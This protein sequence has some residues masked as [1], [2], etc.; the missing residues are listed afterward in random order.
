MP[1]IRELINRISFKVNPGD[2]AKADAAMEGMEAK[3]AGTIAFFKSL[4]GAINKTLKAIGLLT[5]AGAK[6]FTEYE[7]NQA[8]SRFFS[9]TQEEAKQL[10]D[11]LDKLSGSEIISKR[12]REQAEAALSK[13]TVP[14]DQIAR[15]LPILED[16]T[17]ARPDLDFEQVVGLTT[18]FVKT[19]D[20]DALENLGAV[21]KDTAEAFRLSQ[22]N[23]STAI[24][25]QRNLFQFLAENLDRNKEKIK[26]NADLVRDDL[27]F[28]FKSLAKEASDF[29]LNFGKE[30]APV[31]KEI[32]IIIRDLIKEL[33]ESDEFWV[34]VKTGAESTL[35]VIKEAIA[36]AKI[37]AG[38][39]EVA[40]I[41]AIDD[42]GSLKT[43]AKNIRNVFD[44]GY[45]EASRIALENREKFAE[46][47]IEKRGGRKEFR[48]QGFREFLDKQ[49]AELNK[50][51]IRESM[52]DSINEPGQSSQRGALGAT[53][54]TGQKVTYEVSFSPLVIEGKNIQNLDLVPMQ[55]ELNKAVINEVRD[56]FI[57]VAAQS[58][59]LVGISGGL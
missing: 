19:G 29:T 40:P 27:G 18:Q 13:L 22:L 7:T 38:D 46:Q 58:G 57:G 33:N 17:V 5:A 52:Q 23:A 32:V 50:V 41:E 47:E 45:F 30:T 54:G 34:S 42:P 12:E 31:V 9:R 6:M 15:I 35:S 43:I 1:I 26:E 2:K 28:S 21:G 53:G 11:A 37:L 4:G 14:V 3:G 59:R 24:K 20:I 16:I 44:K 39:E 10:S 48:D 36:L 51:F 56:T 55:E 25:G 8:V 49:E